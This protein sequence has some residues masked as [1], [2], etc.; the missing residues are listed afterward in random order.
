M[1]LPYA[2]AP[3]LDETFPSW[4]DRLTASLHVTPAAF[5]DYA[6]VESESPR[7]MRGYGIALSQSQMAAL[8]TTT[9]FA[10][11]VIEPTL[12]RGHI[13]RLSGS[14]FDD[15]T[16]LQTTWVYGATSF[17]C[18]ECLAERDRAWRWQWRFPWS[19]AC[20]RHN[21]LLTDVCPRCLTATGHGH[22]RFTAPQYMFAMAWPA[23]CGHALPAPLR[24]SYDGA[25]IC[26]LDLTTAQ[27]T[28]LDWDT[29]LDAQRRL[30][31]VIADG[32]G[33]FAGDDL[34]CHEFLHEM[35][36]A[37]ALLLK[38]A[39]PE[40]FEWPT[41]A[42]D[43]V[44]TYT[45][46][47]DPRRG[48]VKARAP[49]FTEVPRSP[50]VL[51]AL[52]PSAMHF[53]KSRSQR[54][55]EVMVG[56]YARALKKQAVGTPIRVV[57]TRYGF[58]GRIGAAVVE[59]LARQSPT[60]T[61]SNATVWAGLSDPRFRPA[62]IPEL[63]WA[64]AWE[65]LLAG[66]FATK[67]PRAARRFCSLALVRLLQNGTWVDAAV[68]LGMP[69]QRAKSP[70]G[71]MT[72]LNRRGKLPTFVA[73]LG[74]VA[75]GLGRTRPL[76]DYEPR[77]DAL[78]HLKE[79]ATPAEIARSSWTA[80]SMY[81]RCAAAWIWEEFAGGDA[82]CSPSIQHATRPRTEAYYRFLAMAS[83]SDQEEL[84]RYAQRV[85]AADKHR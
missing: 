40:L 15:P 20:C 58:R 5:L 22:L 34:R 16:K 8:S 42:A 82:L 83:P 55:L 78:R 47:I 24:S 33:Y 53:A 77:R 3:E 72:A 61:F 13:A 65:Q 70:N 6:G 48:A 50:E 37:C 26:R 10:S 62:N 67:R 68:A 66:F 18:P 59:A 54:E 35:R 1:R 17:L 46:G 7:R 25:R 9:G 14:P 84:L 19:F 64:D 79:I 74:S 30:D 36:S 31:A 52:L 4:I 56:P 41:W 71:Y 11:D 80:Q 27:V 32:W 21:A 2:V 73:T 51:S 29:A 23:H 39:E 69:P 63:I 28:R 43:A 44:A 85:V 45:A 76:V 49:F 81:R 38:T 75:R 60:R 57:A 12:L